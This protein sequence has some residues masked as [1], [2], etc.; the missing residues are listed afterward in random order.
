MEQHPNA[1]QPSTQQLSEQLALMQK[2]SDMQAQ[3]IQ[4]QRETTDSLLKLNETLCSDIATLKTSVNERDAEI[5]RLVTEREELKGQRIG[6]VQ[7]NSEFAT[8]RAQVAQLTRELDRE[9][10]LSNQRAE[11][12]VALSNSNAARHQ[13]MQRHLSRITELETQ[14]RAL[15]DEQ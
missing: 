5:A 14:L 7:A 13:D 3:A 8:L 10:N 12:I 11:R 4:A 6:L 2:V 9:V 15:R 1:Q